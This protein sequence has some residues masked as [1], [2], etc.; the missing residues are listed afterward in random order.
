MSDFVKHD[1]GHLESGAVVTITVRE[2]ANVRLFDAGNFNRYQRGEQCRFLGGQALRSPV[3]LQVPHADHWY[4][5]L[6]FGGRA[7]T[8]HSNVTVTR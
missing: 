2:R 8:I 6:D 3:T 5:A 4:V 1:L 7:G